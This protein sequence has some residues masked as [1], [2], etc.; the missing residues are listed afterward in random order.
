[1]SYQ[2]PTQPGVAGA[3][4]GEDPGQTL[5][6]VGII[7]AFVAA[8]IGIIVSY[9]ARKKSRESGRADNQLGKIGFI[10]GIVFTVVGVVF[11]ILYIAVIA[12]AIS[13]GGM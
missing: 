2:P 13:A 1:M 10:L 5:G 9:L 6:I 11:W 7:L 12:A 8:P 3:P 4:A